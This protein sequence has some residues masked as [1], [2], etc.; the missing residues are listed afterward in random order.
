MPA[1]TAGYSGFVNG[2]T[3]SVLDGAPTCTTTATSTSPVGTYPTSCFGRGRRQLTISYADGE[4]TVGPAPSRRSR[5][6]RRRSPTAGA[7]PTITAVVLGLR[8]RRHASSLSTRP[9]VHDPGHVGQP[10]GRATDQL[11]GSGRPELHHQLHRRIGAG[12][13]GVAH[14]HRLVGSATYGGAVPAIRPRTSGFVNGG[15]GIVADHPPTCTTTATSASPVGNYPTSCSGAVD[16]NYTITYVGGTAAGGPGATGRHGVVGLDDLR[17]HAADDHPGV[18]L[19]LRERGQRRLA[20]APRRLY[21]DGRG[22]RARSGTYPT[23]CSG[24]A[25]PNYTISYVRR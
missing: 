3:A 22:R 4:A 14:G 7:A 1:V 16:P 21:D 19:G 5:P 6:R 17:R 25:D 11:L 2:D 15:H 23:A 10:C 20:S 18:V 13:P 24:A 12:G 9:D 8:E